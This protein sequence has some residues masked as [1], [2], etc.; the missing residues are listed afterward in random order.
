MLLDE[1]ENFKKFYHLKRGFKL[2]N[3]NNENSLYNKNN[4]L[5][6]LIF[7]FYKINLSKK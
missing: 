4:F 5:I 6:F 7:Y 2:I 3:N 1:N